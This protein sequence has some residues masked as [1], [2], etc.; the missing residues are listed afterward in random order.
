MLLTIEEAGIINGRLHRVDEL[1]ERGVRL[2]TLTW[3]HENCLGFPNSKDPRLMELGLK[4]L[5]FE[6]RTHGESLEFWWM[7]LIYLTGDFT[8]WLLLLK[9]HL[10][11]PILMPEHCAP[12][13]EIL[14]MICFE[15]LAHMAAWPALICI[16]NSEKIR[17]YR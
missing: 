2:M 15:F 3:N 4:P 17:L 1:Y 14:R 5:G 11:L 8:M 6:R 7:C 9:A 10:W 13:Q 12:I 16:R